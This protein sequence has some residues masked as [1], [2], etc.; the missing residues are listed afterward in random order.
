MQVKT[1]LSANEGF[2]FSALS[3]SNSSVRLKGFPRMAFWLHML[4][5]KRIDSRKIVRWKVASS[6]VLNMQ[7]AY[8]RMRELENSSGF[9]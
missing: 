4:R 3:L 7:M 5:G 6:V 2:G 1:T 8:S 9:V